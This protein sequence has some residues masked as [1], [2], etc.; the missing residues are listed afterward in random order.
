M[1]KIYNLFEKLY[2]KKIDPTGLALFRIFFGFILLGEVVQIFNFKYLIFINQMTVG[3]IFIFDGLLWIWCF[4][5]LFLVI[6]LFTRYVAIV[7]YV[8]CVLIFGT[9]L[10]ASYH[11]DYIYIGVSFLLIFTSSSE[12]LSVD[13]FIKAYKSKIKNQ[14]VFI[15]DIS[16]LNYFSIVLVGIGFIYFDSIFHKLA[17]VT[18]TT[19]LGVW[20]PASLPQFT[21]LDLNWLMNQKYIIVFLSY[22]TL[23]LEFIFIFIFWNKKA[24]LPIFIVGLGLHIGIFI[25]FPI[26]GFALTMIALYILLIPLHFIKKINTSYK[27]FLNRIFGQTTEQQIRDNLQIPL[28]KK[29]HIYAIITYFVLIMSLQLGVI[30]RSP[31]V[32][33]V[34]INNGWTVS[35]PNKV[36][37]KISSNISPL[38]S[39]GFF[40]IVSHSVFL[41]FHYTGY[42]HIIAITYIE[43]N[44]SETW[45][46]ITN[47][48][49]QASWYNV[50]RNWTYIG[51][52]MV[53]PQVDST[54][55]SN[56]IKRFTEFYA[57]KNDIDLEDATFKVKVKKIDIPME[58]EKDFLKTQMAQPWQDVS[59]AKWIDGKYFIDLP[60]I[61]SL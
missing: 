38:I 61:E 25:T 36:F 43:K 48:Q 15:S 5:L 55:L 12:T 13:S 27:A 2:D 4:S 60:D 57:V 30:Y 7:S 59:E 20:K 24:R 51:F 1:K 42:N 26:P 56:G 18:W 33:K 37:A 47:P 29:I 9:S 28:F 31:L 41:D 22:L 53:G 35:F 45:L 8:C 10:I 52:G 54:A 21:F 34:V 40:G 50:G 39:Q 46:P 44:G 19:G 49:G 3:K 6:G 17:S 58:W 32:K 23:F 16:V 11:A 14:P